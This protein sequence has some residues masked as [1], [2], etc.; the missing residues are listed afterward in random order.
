MSMVGYLQ[1]IRARYCYDYNSTSLVYLVTAIRSSN[2]LP[3][4]QTVPHQSN[5]TIDGED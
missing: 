3:S 1:W 2:C 4:L 5:S